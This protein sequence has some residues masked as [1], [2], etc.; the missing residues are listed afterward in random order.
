MLRGF[1]ALRGA[2][3]IAN[4]AG[5]GKGKAKL[6]EIPRCAPNDDRATGGKEVG[7]GTK[8]L[9]FGLYRP[10]RPPSAAQRSVIPKEQSD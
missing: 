9:Q 7:R 5:I 2:A 4:A 6:F 1:Y 8:H 10:P 3:S